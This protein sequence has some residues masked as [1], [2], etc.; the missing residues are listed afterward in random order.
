MTRSLLLLGIQT[1]V[2]IGI[3]DEFELLVVGGTVA[4]GNLSLH[5]GGVALLCN[6]LAQNLAGCYALTPE[7]SGIGELKGENGKRETAVY[8]LSGRCV[9]KAQKGIFICDGKKVFL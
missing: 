2:T 5:Y 4:I 1:P 8:D 6:L 3:L 7:E 9:Q